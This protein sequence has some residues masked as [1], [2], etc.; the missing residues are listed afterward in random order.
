VRKREKGENGRKM[1]REKLESGKK[2]ERY[3]NVHTHC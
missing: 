3:C 2:E 1:E